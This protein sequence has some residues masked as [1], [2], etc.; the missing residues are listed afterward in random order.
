MESA[1]ELEV[2]NKVDYEQGD[3]LG[4]NKIMNESYLNANTYHQYIVKFVENIFTIWIPNTIKKV[5]IVLS[6]VWQALPVVQSI[7]S[8]HYLPNGACLLEIAYISV[9]P[10]TFF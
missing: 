8:Y 2:P 9:F 10:K 5:K 1:V 3:K 7:L 6:S 4:R